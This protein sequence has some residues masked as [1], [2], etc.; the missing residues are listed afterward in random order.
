M[1]EAVAEEIFIDF[2][3]FQWLAINAPEPEVCLCLG[4]GGGKTWTGSRWILSR[5]MDFPDSVHLATI[6]SYTQGKDLVIPALEDAADQMG[7]EWRWVGGKNAP[8]LVVDLGDC[9][10]EIRLRSTEKFNKLRGPEIGSWW[11]DEVRDAPE[12]ALKIVMMRLRCKKVDVPRTLMTTTPNGQ[13]EIYRMFVEGS[14]LS[15]MIH[16]PKTGLKIRVYRSKNGR[17]LMINGP[18][19]LNT[20]V[21]EGYVEFMGESLTGRL[22]KQERDGEFVP[23]GDIVYEDFSDE[24]IST[25]ATYDARLPIFVSLDFN[26]KPC[27]A[28]I[29]QEI[30]GETCVVDEI[31][32]DK[33]GTFAVVAEFKRR[34]PDRV[35]HRA[36]RIYGDASGH[37]QDTRNGKSDYAIWTIEIPGCVLLVP[38]ANGYVS[39]RINAVN[40]RCQN[41]QGN[42]FLFVNPKCREAIEDFRGVVYRKHEREPEKKKNPRRTHVTDAVG[43]YVVAVHPLRRFM[44]SEQLRHGDSQ[45]WQPK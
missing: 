13:D 34:Y 40:F 38:K 14:A 16:D 7:L 43:Y 12:E 10:S 42:R 28:V 21:R 30:N 18:T 20:K 6:N 23:T 37:H 33:G 35:G 11:P 9:R 5:L 1:S 17:R 8:N 41:A 44:D 22:L 45:L 27:V 25:R 3:P 36:P 2:Q 4:S 31:I 15:E 26:V 24:N 32:C 39:D 29:I 19:G